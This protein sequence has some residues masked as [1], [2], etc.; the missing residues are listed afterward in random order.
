MVENDPTETAPDVHALRRRKRELERQLKAAEPT[1]LDRT[2]AVAAK[3]F[4]PILRLPWA[5]LI[6]LV[7]V[8]A[9]IAAGGYLVGAHENMA[10]AEGKG[11]H[12]GEVLGYGLAG[13][14]IAFVIAWS[15]NSIKAI[16]ERASP[17]ADDSIRSIEE[18]RANRKT[19]LTLEWTTADALMA[20]AACLRYSASYLGFIVLT[21]TGMMMA[22]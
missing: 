21:A 2:R 14:F 5:T 3:A 20:L 7:V 13:A 22:A 8:T 12:M 19:R 15:L 11:A 18:W 4:A 6:L 10:Y 9:V 16:R 1:W 17:A